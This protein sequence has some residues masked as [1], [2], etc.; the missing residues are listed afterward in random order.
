RR[1]VTIPL[2]LP[3]DAPMPEKPIGIPLF[4][5]PPD[6]NEWRR[7][8]NPWFSPQT[9]ARLVPGMRALTNQLIDDFIETGSADL[10][11]GLVSPMPAIVICRIIG[12]PEE[13]WHSFAD[14]IHE[15]L[16]RH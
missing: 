9:T 16:Q 12:L 15:S 2:N 7:M 4:V 13:D 1:G 6:F 8:L 3:D 10:Y 5:D 14:P 11:D